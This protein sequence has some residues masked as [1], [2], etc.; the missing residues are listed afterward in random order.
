MIPSLDWEWSDFHSPAIGGDQEDPDCIHALSKV[1][2]RP[3]V[4]LSIFEISFLVPSNLF[5]KFQIPTEPSLLKAVTFFFI[6]CSLF[7]LFSFTFEIMYSNLL[8]PFLSILAVLCVSSISVQA[9]D[10]GSPPT[11]NVLG[12]KCEHPPKIAFPHSSIH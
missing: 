4:L 5:P 9:I 7:L 1:W 3:M 8:K 11:G 2:H 6:M 12:R 10:D